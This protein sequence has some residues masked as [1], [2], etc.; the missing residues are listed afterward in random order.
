MVNDA[1]WM[2]AENWILSK[3]D[4]SIQEFPKG[5]RR[6][7]DTAW[8]KHVMTLLEDTDFTFNQYVEWVMEGGGDEK[9]QE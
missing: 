1:A 8:S 4:N 9:F 7:L 5:T 2:D 6:Y 3:W